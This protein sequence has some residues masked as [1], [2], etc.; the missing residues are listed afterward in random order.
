MTNENDI[1]LLRSKFQKALLR[2]PKD[3]KTGKEYQPLI[4]EVSLEDESIEIEEKEKSATLRK[5]SIHDLKFQDDKSAIEAI[6]RVNLETSIP[7]ISTQGKTAEVAL[8]I[9]R[10]YEAKN[11]R[12][13]VCLIEMKSSL[14]PRRDE[15][16]DGKITIK[17][18]SLTDIKEKI[19]CSMNRMY[20]L[21]S[22]NNHQNRK[23]YSGVNI[24]IKFKGIIIFNRHKLSSSDDSDLYKIFISPKKSRLLTVHTILGDLNKIEIKFFPRENNQSEEHRILQL[25][26]LL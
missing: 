16:K 5:V 19:E 10:R 15:E 8:M 11:Y 6:W 20:M 21:M 26:D 4:E 2:I 13:N 14:Q 17:P 9:L 18:S 23:G 25:S 3:P 12:L 7:G 22:L 24:D 1:N